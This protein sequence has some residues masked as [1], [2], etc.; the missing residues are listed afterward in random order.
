MDQTAP[1]LAANGPVLLRRAKGHSLLPPLSTDFRLLGAHRLWRH[2]IPERLLYAPTMIRYPC[3]H[4][5]RPLPIPLRNP[6]PTALH[7]RSQLH[8]QRGM[9]PPSV[10]T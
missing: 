5:W 9:W 2:R 8:A 6:S 7:W 1:G 10:T 4:R 3:R